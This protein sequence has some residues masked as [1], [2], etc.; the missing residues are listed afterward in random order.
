M[1]APERRSAPRTER[2]RDALRLVPTLLRVEAGRRHPRNRHDRAR[3][4]DESGC[5]RIVQRSVHILCTSTGL[6]SLPPHPFSR[7]PQLPRRLER[8]CHIRL[9]SATRLD[10][11]GA[12][13]R[14]PRRQRARDPPGG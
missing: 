13:A 10:G 3:P 1:S 12:S 14:K 2:L 9:L 5:A 7:P 11:G 8:H 6:S 4:A